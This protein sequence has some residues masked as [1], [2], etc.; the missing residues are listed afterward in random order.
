[1]EVFID[2]PATLRAPPAL[3]VDDLGHSI[4]RHLVHRDSLELIL[5]VLVFFQLSA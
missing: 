3:T 4:D 5:E 1:L 2:E